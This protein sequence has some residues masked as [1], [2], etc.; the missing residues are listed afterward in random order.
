MADTP[1]TKYR[2]DGPKAAWDTTEFLRHGSG[3]EQVVLSRTAP[4]DDRVIELSDDEAESLKQSQKLHKVD[5]SDSQGESSQREG[6]GDSSGDNPKGSEQ[7][8][9]GATGAAA[10]GSGASRQG[11]G[12]GAGQS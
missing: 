4:A 2:W 8:Q 5:G 6:A 10:S 1:K 12:K 9:P 7:Q 3:D 11:G